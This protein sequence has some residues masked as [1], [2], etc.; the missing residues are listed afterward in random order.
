MA[1]PRPA[2]GP[3]RPK[4]LWARGTWNEKEEEFFRMPLGWKG[5]GAE[6]SHDMH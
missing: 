6:S 3:I 4:I 5:Q 2:L 1:K